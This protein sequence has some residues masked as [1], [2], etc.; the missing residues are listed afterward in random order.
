MAKGV[1]APKA[2]T[3]KE[4]EEHERTHV[5]YRSWC[6][7]CV[8][9]RGRNKHHARIA[10]DADEEEKSRKVGRVSMD[11]VFMSKKDRA[12]GKN[13]VLAMID[14]RSGAVFARAVGR[15]GVGE[16][17]EMEWL[18]KSI[19]EE[20]EEWG[21]RGQD[22]ILKNDQE[23]SIEALAKAISDMRVGKTIPEL[24]PRGESQANVKA[25]DAGRR[26]REYARVYKDQLEDRIQGIIE[27]GDP[28]MQW[29]IRWAGMVI[30]R[31]VVGPDG[32]TAYERI[33]GRKCRTDVVK[34]G[35]KVLYRKLKAARGGKVESDW[36]EGVWLGHNNRS[37]QVVIGTQDGVVAAWAVKRKI[38]E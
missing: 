19:V 12:E 22:M 24:A 3:K 36:E 23:P 8:R 11:Y 5:P 20:T 2:P 29:I 9:G 14:E 16:N 26:V 34:I 15:K 33:R 21:Y 10:E 7:H 32:K 17:R 25:E 35:E 6:K 38:P 31:Y 37:S 30:S 4:R 1:G 18:I 28:I 27:P 13:P